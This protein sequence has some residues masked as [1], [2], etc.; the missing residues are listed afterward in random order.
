MK[1]KWDKR[2]VAGCIVSAAVFGV[3]MALFMNGVF[4]F[5][6][7]AKSEGSDT[8]IK[9]IRQASLHRVLQRFRFQYHARHHRDPCRRR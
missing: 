5:L 1:K 7:K 2:F 6:G 4:S 3:I 9:A 8:L